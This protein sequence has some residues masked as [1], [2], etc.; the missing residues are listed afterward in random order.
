M[1]IVSVI[2]NVTPEKTTATQSCKHLQSKRRDKTD[3][4]TFIKKTSLLSRHENDLWVD[5]STKRLQS[6]R[7]GALYDGSQFKGVQKCGSNKYNV[8]VDI[9]HVDLAASKISG[10]L[11][12]EGLTSECPELTTF[13]EGEIIGPQYSF[14]TRKWQ[15]QQS[16]DVLHWVRRQE[17]LF[18]FMMLM[19]IIGTFSVI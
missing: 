10:Y 3:E 12:I 4:K 17:R 9:Q 14:L 18:Y 6:T 7:L 15:A 13:F 8:V 2:T 5:I 11:N 19:I 1:P 16:I